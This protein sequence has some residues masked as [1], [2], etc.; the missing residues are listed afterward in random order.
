MSRQLSCHSV[1]SD[2]N[3][4]HIG[5]VAAGAIA[6]LYLKQVYGVEIVAF[7]SSVGKINIPAS[8]G[9]RAPSHEE[10][11][12]EIEEALTPEFRQLLS[13]VTREMVDAHP[14]RCPHPET[15]ERMTKV[16]TSATL[17]VHKPCRLSCLSHSASSVRRKPTTPSA[18]PS[19]A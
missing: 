2:L 8:V 3:K 1:L 16:S 10:D 4:W 5:R 12:D 9:G 6:E 7:V 17:L 13:S 15:A 18:A 11:N 19:P 14:T